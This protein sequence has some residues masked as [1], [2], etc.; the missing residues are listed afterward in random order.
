MITLIERFF[1]IAIPVRP[2]DGG[3]V[4]QAVRKKAFRN[5]D[6]VSDSQRINATFHLEL[7]RVRRL[8]PPHLF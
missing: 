2:I 4:F 7:H 8:P 1:S 6:L 5:L 3:I